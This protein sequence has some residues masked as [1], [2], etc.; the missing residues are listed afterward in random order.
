VILYSCTVTV[1]IVTILSLEMSVLTH[2]GNN[3]HGRP[4]Q[5]RVSLSAD[6]GFWVL[7]VSTGL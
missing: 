1:T 5:V 7:F 4:S 2:L 6:E 3:W